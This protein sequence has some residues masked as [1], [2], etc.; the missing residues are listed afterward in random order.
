MVATPVD[1]PEPPRARA[2]RGTLFDVA[3]KLQKD[4]RAPLERGR[5]FGAGIL[6]TRAVGEKERRLAMLKPAAVYRASLDTSRG[7][8]RRGA[9]YLP[10]TDNAR[11]V[12]VDSVQARSCY[13]IAGSATVLARTASTL[14]R[15]AA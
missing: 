6:K 3:P 8:R 14:V 2:E 7:V 1:W 13:R 9:H 4:G 5:Q 11:T 12:E 10:P 15:H